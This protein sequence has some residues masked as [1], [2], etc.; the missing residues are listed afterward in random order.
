MI[1]FSISLIT[2]AINQSHSVSELPVM[3]LRYFSHRPGVYS[4]DYGPGFLSS[5][6]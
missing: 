5:V 2:M 6:R 4:R 3:V 1:F